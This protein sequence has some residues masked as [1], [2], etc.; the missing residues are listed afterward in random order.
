MLPSAGQDPYNFCPLLSSHF[1]PRCFK[2]LRIIQDI[3]LLMKDKVI[4][5]KRK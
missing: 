4:V 3:N 1:V 5:G 2:E